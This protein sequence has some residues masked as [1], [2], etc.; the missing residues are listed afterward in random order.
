M[1]HFS[2][3]VA[4]PTPPNPAPHTA[5]ADVASGR[6]NRFDGS[7][8]PGIAP[9]FGYQL[10]QFDEVDGERFVTTGYFARGIDGDV[11]INHSRFHFHPTQARFDALAAVGFPH[12]IGKGIGPISDRDVDALIV[13]AAIADER[14]IDAATRARPI[15]LHPDPFRSHV[16]AFDA[17]VRAETWRRYW[18]QPGFRRAYDA[19]IA[20]QRAETLAW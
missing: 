4:T 20:Q 7:P 11:S 3:A 1:R 12:A 14:I 13:A 16:Q 8:V 10:M 5:P 6:G 2:R 17:L 19:R 9:A 15:T 18:S